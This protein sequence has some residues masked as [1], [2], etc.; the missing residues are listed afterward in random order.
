ML[1]IKPVGLIHWLSHPGPLLSQRVTQVA[2]G[3][4]QLPILA[5]AIDGAHVP[6][7]M[8]RPS[9]QA[10]VGRESVLGGPVCDGNEG[11][12]RFP[13]PPGG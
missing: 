8:L 12:Q 7:A 4:K 9:N 11:G 2:A 6:P 1:K 5:L 13:L 10:G 3:K